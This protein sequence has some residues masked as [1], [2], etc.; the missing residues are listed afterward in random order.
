MYGKFFLP[1]GLGTIPVSN[2][3]LGNSSSAACIPH[4]LRLKV[5]HSSVVLVCMSKQPLLEGRSRDKAIYSHLILTA[6]YQTLMCLVCINLGG[7]SACGHV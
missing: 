4:F 6:R 3:H 1:F 2:N 7:L 5:I